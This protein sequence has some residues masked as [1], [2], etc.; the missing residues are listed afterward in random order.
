MK[1]LFYLFVAMVLMGCEDT[2]ENTHRYSNIISQV[3]GYP[4]YL[5]LD[6]IDNIQVVSESP[7][8]DPFKIVSGDNH[9]FVGDRLKGVHVYEKR[10]RKA[11]YLCFIE[12]MYI[13]DLEVIDNH[14]YCNNLTDMVVIDVSNPTEIN[15]LHRQKNHFNRFAS[16]SQHWNIPFE[17]EKG[18]VVGSASYSLTGVVTDE[19][20]ELDFSE[21]DM[22]YGNLTVD[23][24]PDDWFSNPPELSK[25]YVGIINPGTDEIHTFGKYNSWTI[26]S[27]RAGALD[28]REEDLWTSGR[29]NYAPPYYY[30]NAFP[31]RMFYKDD[32]IFI[33][34]TENNSV[35]SYIDCII[36]DEQFPITHHL[37]LSDFR[38]LDACYMPHLNTF[39]LLSETSLWGVFIRGNGVTGYEK[40]Y[41]DFQVSSGAVEIFSIGNKLLTIGEELSV[42]DTSGGELN[43]VNSVSG[44]NGTCSYTEE[45][46]LIVANTQGV[47]FYDITDLENIQLIP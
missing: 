2:I 20:P 3:K 5:D 22:L 34:G 32:I 30:S 13:K 17:E 26:I 6:E 37:Y 1:H 36:Y 15:I 24:I 27:Y 4:I 46:T 40:T 45:N 44:I 42:Y 35:S 21:Y 25:P 10:G 41:K 38:P 43:L 18:V 39:Y 23:E 14:L 47:S 33:S 28:I 19:Q 7:V 8:E 31:V 12:C 29:G 16:Y 9:Y 11:S